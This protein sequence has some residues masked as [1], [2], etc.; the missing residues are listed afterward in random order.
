MQASKNFLKFKH[1]SGKISEC[2]R[3]SKNFEW[4]SRIAELKNSAK[5]FEAELLKDFLECLKNCESFFKHT[6]VDSVISQF[7]FLK[8]PRNYADFQKYSL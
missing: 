3:N 7:Q 8:V 1:I 6:S 5:R 4:L 2:S